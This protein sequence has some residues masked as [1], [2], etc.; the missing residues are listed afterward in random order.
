MHPYITSAIIVLVIVLTFIYSIWMTFTN[1]SA[2]SRERQ[3]REEMYRQVRDLSTKVQEVEHTQKV[4]G[5]SLS[6][7]H[8]DG[9][10]MR[11]LLIYNYRV[12]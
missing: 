8:I 1:W 5:A 3:N 2:Q 9:T 6:E 11:K 7:P 4:I 10:V 12:Y